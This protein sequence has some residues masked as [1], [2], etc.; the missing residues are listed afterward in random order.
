VAKQ[1][2]RHGTDKNTIFGRLKAKPKNKVIA[3]IPPP[4]L[5]PSFLD[6]LASFIPLD[7]PHMTTTLLW[8]ADVLRIQRQELHLVQFGQA[9]IEFRSIQPKLSTKP[10]NNSPI[11]LSRFARCVEHQ[12]WISIELWWLSLNF[13]KYVGIGAL[14]IFWQIF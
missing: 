4:P 6:P 12:N 9:V 5:S 10:A 3:T 2:S 11:R 1:C 7:P 8:W 14:R 13:T